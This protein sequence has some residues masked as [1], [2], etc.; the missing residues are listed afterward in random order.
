MLQNVPWQVAAKVDMLRVIL[1]M[2]GRPVVGGAASDTMTIQKAPPRAAA[3]SA[4]LTTLGR[5]VIPV[6][7]RKRFGIGDRDALEISVQGDTIVRSTRTTAFCGSDQDLRRFRDRA[8]CDRLHDAADRRR[9]LGDESLASSGARRRPDA[10]GDVGDGGALR[11]QALTTEAFDRR[12]Q[13]TDLWRTGLVQLDQPGVDPV[14]RHARQLRRQRRGTLRAH[15]RAPARP[16]APSQAGRATGPPHAST[17]VTS[18]FGGC[19]N[20]SPALRRHRARPARAAWSAHGRRRSDAAGSR[21]GQPGQRGTAAAAVTRRPRSGAPPDRAGRAAPA[22]APAERGRKPAN[23]KP[24][25]A[26]PE[27][28]SAAVTADGPGST[29][30]STPAA[31]ASARASARRDRTPPGTPRPTAGRCARPLGRSAAAAPASGHARCARAARS[32]AASMPWRASSVRE[33]RVSS[34]AATS[35]RRSSSSTRSVTS[36]RLPIGWGRRRGRRAFHLRARAR[37]RPAR[38]RRC[39]VRRPRSARRRLPAAPCAR[40]RP[41]P[42]PAAPRPQPKSRLRSPPAPG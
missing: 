39:P 33:W 41:A 31:I 5:I 38:R 29:T 9:G 36:L 11:E 42:V 10:V 7:I 15:C 1:P 20:R 21:C 14:T 18:P 28:T 37:P 12:V 13:G 23:T 6:E 30:T 25:P 17:S 27:A 22:S 16:G 24:P 2:C 26:I 40:T 34:Q 35:A 32:A 4:A 8:V 19:A 3:L